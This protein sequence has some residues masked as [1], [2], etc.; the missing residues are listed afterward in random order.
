VASIC[1]DK[2]NAVAAKADTVGPTVGTGETTIAV[3]ASEAG[4]VVTAHV[5][6][7]TDAVADR[8]VG[9]MMMVPETI[10]SV[11]AIRLAVPATTLG[12]TMTV[13]TGCW[14]AAVAPTTPTPTN[15]V[16][17]GPTTVAV[18]VCG[19]GRELTVGVVPAA[20]A[21]AVKALGSRTPVGAGA[22][23]LPVA[24]MAA[25]NNVVTG[26][27]AIVEAV[28][29]NTPARTVGVGAGATA[30]ALATVLAVMLFV[31]SSR[32]VTGHVPHR[33]TL[34]FT[35]PSSAN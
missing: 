14:A 6:V 10:E 18:A 15:T 22:I 19:D 32:I 25:G 35:I 2:T 4:S 20:E 27:G 34:M 23:T 26:T 13:G 16:Q 8:T 12:S 11:G 21:V 30:D 28:A 24:A 31:M 33:Y 9:V 29:A 17:A 1:T 5:G 7:G 3:V